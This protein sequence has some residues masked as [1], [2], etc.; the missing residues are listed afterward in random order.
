[1]QKAKVIGHTLR[2]LLHT[3]LLFLG[4]VTILA[5]LGYAFFGLR[6]VLWAV[7]ISTPMLLIGQRMSPR[8]MLRLYGARKI[9]PQSAPTLYH[10]L[11]ALAERADL[12]RPPEIYY[13]PSRMVNAFSVGGRQRAAI[14]ITDGVFRSLN[15]RELVG[16]LAHEVA[17]IHNNDMR[18]MGFADM[19]SRLT[20][21]LARTGQL[22]LLFNLPML[23]M[24]G[25]TISWAGVLLLLGAP[26]LTGL[27][28]LALSRTREYQADLIAARLTADPEG[29][30]SALTKMEAHHRNVLEQILMPNHRGPEPSL[31]RTHP[32]T[33]DRVA[34]L[35]SLRAPVRPRITEEVG[36]EVEMP[37]P[38]PTKHREPQWYITG[39]WR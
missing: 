17:H 15:Q 38:M 6:A 24:G 32:H 8:L 33:E 36:G 31:F 27:M 22:L 1:M 30:A 21:F 28:Q 7:I 35:L 39:I 25:P 16:V 26:S 11:A 23:L 37:P 4:M 14:G 18:V 9:A 10:T 3:A 13:I 5:A 29:L 20:G 19:I 12:P 34:R 2:N